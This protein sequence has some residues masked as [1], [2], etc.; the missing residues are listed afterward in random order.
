MSPKLPPRHRG[1]GTERGT[2]LGQPPWEPEALPCPRA[3]ALP[4]GSRTSPSSS[5]AVT[6]PGAR[7][8][9]GAGW[10][11]RTGR[12]GAEVMDA[13]LTLCLREERRMRPKPGVK[14][15]AS[16]RC[17]APSPVQP[18]P[19]AGHQLGATARR[20][21]PLPCSG[22]SRFPWGRQGKIHGT[23]WLTCSWGRQDCLGVLPVPR[24]SLRVPL[25]CLKT[26]H[27][28]AA[29]LTKPGE[30]EVTQSS[31]RICS[32]RSRTGLGAGKVSAGT[33]L[34]PGGQLASAWWGG[35]THAEE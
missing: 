3:A 7:S 12:A 1:A 18:P 4:H 9:P 35:C 26:P 31:P 29:P 10:Q 16:R 20:N 22:P 32:L 14:V 28:L 34:Q 24:A 30:K 17:P 21:R 19:R 11:P 13:L 25:G 2:K 8:P 27:T 33:Y 23:T 5:L 6:Q 15:A